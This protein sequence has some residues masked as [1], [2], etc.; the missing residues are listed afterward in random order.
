MSCKLNEPWYVGT[1][2]KCEK[3][4]TPLP[5]FLFCINFLPVVHLE[6]YL[7]PLISQFGTT[8]PNATT[9]FDCHCV[10]SVGSRAHVSAAWQSTQNHTALKTYSI[11]QQHGVAWGFIKDIR[12]GNC[13]CYASLVFVM[14]SKKAVRYYQTAC[15]KFCCEQWSL[16][17]LKRNFIY[18]M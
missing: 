12:P 9:V 8:L 10:G 2:A 11:K 17:I 5:T 7:Q 14:S 13:S 3:R 15:P 1:T 4:D 16:Q 18:Y 6:I